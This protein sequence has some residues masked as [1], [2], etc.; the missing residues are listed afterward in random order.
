[1]SLQPPSKVD[2]RITNPHYD[3]PF[4]KWYDGIF[5]AVYIALHPFCKI[6]CIGPQDA[7]RPVQNIKRSALPPEPLTLDTVRSL[8]QKY[9]DSFS[10]DLNTLQIEEKQRGIPVSWDHVKM[11]CGFQSIAKLNKA[12]L[13]IIMA[14]SGEHAD[15]SA[16]ENLENYCLSNQI[17]LPTE[18]TFPPVMQKKITSLL[19]ALCVKEV[20]LADEFNENVCAFKLESLEVPLPWMISSKQNFRPNKIYATDHSFL[21]IVPYDNFYTAVCGNRKILESNGLPMTFEGFWCTETTRPEWWS[22]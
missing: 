20:Y 4:L 17:F 18:D 8:S 22:E 6:E 16:I 21:M 13:T 9:Q 10:M 1:M 14:I 15:C 2:R 5:D 7:P 12:L 19:K 11:A 3:M